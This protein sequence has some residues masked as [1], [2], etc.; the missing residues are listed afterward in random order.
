MKLNWKSVVA[1]LIAAGIGGVI[2]DGIY[3]NLMKIGS[4]AD[5]DDKDEDE[6]EDE[7]HKD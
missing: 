4:K 5:S 3:K 7:D 1:M 2:E 6:D